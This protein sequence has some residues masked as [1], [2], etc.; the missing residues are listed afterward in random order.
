MQGRARCT[1]QPRLQHVIALKGED[2]VQRPGGRRFQILFQVDMKN[3]YNAASNSIKWPLLINI[4][5]FVNIFCKS[6]LHIIDKLK[7]AL[8]GKAFSALNI[9]KIKFLNSNYT[10]F[11]LCSIFNELMHNA[12]LSNFHVRTDGHILVIK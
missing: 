1:G 9:L 4:T 3:I 7:H 2:L 5:D 8:Q 11:A 6:T 10:K 12:Q